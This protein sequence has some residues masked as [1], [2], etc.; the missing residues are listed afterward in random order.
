MASTAAIVVLDLVALIF[1]GEEA[2]PFIR[3]LIVSIAWML[4]LQR[5]KRV[6]N[7]FVH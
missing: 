1:R 6:A 3:T 5:S 2:E 7:T 4:Y